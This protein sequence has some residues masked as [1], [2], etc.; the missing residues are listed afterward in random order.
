MNRMLIET[1]APQHK[2]CLLE[3]HKKLTALPRPNSNRPAET[4]SKSKS[5]DSLGSILGAEVFLPAGFDEHTVQ[6]I[7]YADLPGG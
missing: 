7:G 4:E 3:I 5:G 2:R 6:L 1:R